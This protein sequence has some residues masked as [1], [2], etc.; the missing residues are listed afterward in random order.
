RSARWCGALQ[1]GFVGQVVRWCLEP[2]ARLRAG[3]PTAHAVDP[4]A[5]LLTRR[6]RTPAELSPEAFPAPASQEGGF[7]RLFG[8][9]V[10]SGSSVVTSGP[11]RK[12]RHTPPVPHGLR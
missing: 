10:R 3:S 11:A 2:T 5:G 9:T 1:L 12:L 8:D 7:D 4:N 6:S